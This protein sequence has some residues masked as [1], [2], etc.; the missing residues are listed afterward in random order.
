MRAYVVLILIAVFGW[1]L[2]NSQSNLT[3]NVYTNADVSMPYVQ[4]S[5]IS[6]KKIVQTNLNGFYSVTAIEGD[7]IIFFNS[8]YEPD[9]VQVKH[10]MLVTHWDVTLQ[11]KMVTLQSVTVSGG[12]Q[13]D[14]LRRRSDYFDVFNNR[15]GITGYNAPANGVGVVFSPLSFF[16][17]KAKEKSKLR[18]RLLKQ[19]EDYYISYRFSPEMVGRLTGLRG[20]SLQ[21][22]LYSYRPSYKFCRKTDQQGFVYYISKS[23]KDFRKPTDK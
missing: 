5:N 12:Y 20:D 6:Q 4:V 15:P 16:S 21:L 18:K 11:L 1:Q 9:T 3:G 22:F 17:K 7:S 2:C 8:G 14:S 13:L 10:S 23:L 19:E